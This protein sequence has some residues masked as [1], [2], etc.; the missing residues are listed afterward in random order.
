[1]TVPVNCLGRWHPPATYTK[2]FG[3]SVLGA[4]ATFSI[5]FTA[6]SEIV[7]SSN[8]RYWVRSQQQE[9][10][11]ESTMTTEAGAKPG[12]VPKQPN[13]ARHSN[14]CFYIQPNPIELNLKVFTR[15]T[16]VSTIAVSTGLAYRCP[17]RQ[18][19]AAAYNFLRSFRHC[20]WPFKMGHTVFEQMLGVSCNVQPLVELTYC[21]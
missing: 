13:S 4:G 20:A 5:V 19:S 1:M 14:H 3:K 8:T 2:G 18:N 7:E 15:V 11:T 16:L 17:Q 10:S 21:P 9:N 6:C 12:G